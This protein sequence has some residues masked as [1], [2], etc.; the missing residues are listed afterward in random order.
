VRKGNDFRDILQNA[1]KIRSSI[2]SLTQKSGNRRIVE[3]AAIAGAFDEKIFDDANLAADYATKVAERLNAI[4][5][6]NEKTWKGE[7]KPAGGYVFER[8]MRGV[9][10][11]VRLT[12]DR[13][14]S[15]DARRLHESLEWLQDVFAGPVELRHAEKVL[16]KAN[17]PAALYDGVL[18][19]GRK[20][21]SIQRYKGLGEM[22][23]EQLWVTTLDPNVRTLLKVRIDDAQKAADIFS[24][25]M[26]DVVEPRREFIQDNAL[27]VSNLDV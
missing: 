22:N 18:E 23:P 5:G 11:R 19:Y 6:K 7:F 13:L 26:G 20:G 15:P 1:R 21:L 10:E 4:A 3:Q 9:K 27:K 25:L 16:V 2:H 8:T 17:G 14:R 12:T 24:T